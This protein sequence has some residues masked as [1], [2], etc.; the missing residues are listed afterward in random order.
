MNFLLKCSC[1]LQELNYI[2]RVD[3]SEMLKTPV[4]YLPYVVTSQAK[5]RIV[6]DGKT[7]FEGVCINDFIETGP[8]LLN[9]LANILARFRLGKFVM[10]ADLTKCFF[11][12][13]VP[14]EQC[15]LFC[16]YGL[17]KTMLRREMCLLIG[18]LV[19]LGE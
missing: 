9:P 3:D 4:W 15:N 13:V 17:I 7:A 14:A 16:I 5:K 2:E 19:I 10:M 1:E 11:Q 8:D 6:Y 18:L 12:I